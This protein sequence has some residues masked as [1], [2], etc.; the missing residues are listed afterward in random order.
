LLLLRRD[1]TAVVL[2]KRSALGLL[3]LILL[4]GM[5]VGRSLATDGAA[6]AAARQD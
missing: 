2:T 5:L 1:A 6:G 4:A 3:V